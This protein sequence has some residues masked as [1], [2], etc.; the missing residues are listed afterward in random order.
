MQVYIGGFNVGCGERQPVALST[1]AAHSLFQAPPPLLHQ[2]LNLSDIAL[3]P[4]DVS[5]ELSAREK[6][7]CCDLLLDEFL[8]LARDI[9][10]LGAHGPNLQSACSVVTPP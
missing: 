2:V 3:A 8:H 7:P 1:S 6:S 4:N 5:H 9:D 10:V